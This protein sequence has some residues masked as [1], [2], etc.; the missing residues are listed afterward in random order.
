MLAIYKYTLKKY[1]K[2]WSTWVI[3]GFSAIV[4]GFVIGGMLPFIF[5]DT[6]KQS[7]ASTYAKTIILTIAGITVFFAIFSAI[8]AG[9]KSATMYKDEVENGTFLILIS[10]PMKRIHILFGK[11]FA[12]QTL[13]VMYAFVSVFFLCMGIVIFDNGSHIPGLK[14]M[15]VGSLK[16]NIWYA[17]IYIFLILYLTSLIFSSL[18]IMISTK[19]SVGATIGI[20]IAI[21][22]YIPISGLIGM[23][24]RKPEVSTPPLSNQ[25]ASL[26]VA[27]STI[28]S[29]LKS[30][31]LI[32]N[33]YP[34]LQSKAHDL[35]VTQDT[36]S[37][38]NAAMSSD[39]KDSYPN[40]YWLDLE[41]QFKLLSSYAY[42]SLIPEKYAS[43]VQDSDQLQSA[44]ST[45]QSIKATGTINAANYYASIEKFVTDFSEINDDMAQLL[46]WKH[47]LELQPA[48][49]KDL[50][51][52]IASPESI[53]LVVPG[54]EGKLI[55]SFSNID[56]QN[57]FSLE[58][59]Q[60]LLDENKDCFTD[61]NKAISTFMK[62]IITDENRDSNNFVAADDF[63]FKVEKSILSGVNKKIW[64][65][66]DYYEDGTKYSVNAKYPQTMFDDLKK[67]YSPELVSFL[68]DMNDE[69]NDKN[70]L[71]ISS[72]GTE[73]NDYHF[74]DFKLYKKWMKL[75]FLQEKD[76]QTGKVKY[77]IRNLWSQ[78]INSN[79][80]DQNKQLIMDETYMR[81][82][83]VGARFWHFLAAEMKA[84]GK[85]DEAESVYK[86]AYQ[87]GR[88]IVPITTFV[89]GNNI[90]NDQ[91]E[92]VQVKVRHIHELRKLIDPNYDPVKRYNTAKYSDS[93]Q[94]PMSNLSST[95]LNSLEYALSAMLDHKVVTY[96]SKPYAN[97]DAVL[98]IYA[99]IALALVPL[100]YWVV[101]KQDFR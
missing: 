41:Y 53:G 70:Y 88:M 34:D 38:Y 75:L 97:R 28:D 22:V 39:Q 74:I 57:N 58:L 45:P 18:G 61:M 84:N 35:F 46:T 67:Y 54:K 64:D 11:W 37:L 63:K 26:S 78:D 100:A 80:L 81:S 48:S 98:G 66:Y 19:L 86:D 95:D 3:M 52:F 101:R 21:G 73:D 12:L 10:K 68:Q 30:N 17:S 85:T 49:A 87:I 15:G 36:S 62:W 4:I 1:L 14:S 27:N 7:A 77:P 43:A 32:K 5:I 6:T 13:L 94:D 96:T 71:V 82:Q 65:A 23:F 93:T 79:R 24:A 55:A 42:E 33:L 40:L 90:A 50:I 99:A 92:D 29:Q 31:P 44:M 8:F 25:Q 9:F 69:W 59:L 72:D 20:I 91:Y 76:Q 47:L 2:S 83:L 60:N 89:L 56:T 51:D 16:Q